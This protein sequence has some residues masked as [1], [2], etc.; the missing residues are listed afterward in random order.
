MFKPILCV[1]LLLAGVVPVW[2][3]SVQLPRWQTFDT[4][5]TVTVP[6]RGH[7]VLGGVSRAGSWETRGLGNRSSGHS[8]GSG[9]TDV[10]VYIHDFEALEKE[11]ARK[12]TSRKRSLQPQDQTFSGKLYS[13][14][15][16]PL[17]SA[18][19]TPRRTVSRTELRADLNLSR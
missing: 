18:R 11:A 1:G 3:Q 19:K 13:E 17:P 7:A 6:D 5:T 2:G 16:K 8:V 14:E 12:A 9:Q 10:S 4:R 15:Q